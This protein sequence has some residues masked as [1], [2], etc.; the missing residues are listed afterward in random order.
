MAQWIIWNSKKQTK[1][2]SNHKHVQPTIKLVKYQMTKT[3]KN[4]KNGQ[5]AGGGG[6][7]EM[8]I[9]EEKKNKKKK[10]KIFIELCRLETPER[11][12]Q[13]GNYTFHT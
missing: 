6:E 2:T 12:T 9:Y 11:W 7:V 1:Q 8:E 5:I 10:T 4:N 3:Q 13:T